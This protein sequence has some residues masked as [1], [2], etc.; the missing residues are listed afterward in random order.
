[1]SLHHV[2]YVAV[3]AGFTIEAVRADYGY[4]A[5]LYTFDAGGQIENGNIYVQLKATDR[6]K[7][8][9]DGF[10][11]FRLDKKDIDL[12]EGEP[13]PVYV[14]LFDATAE[15]AYWLHVQKFLQSSNVTA[16]SLTAKTVPARFDPI[17]VVSVAALDTWRQNK[18]AAL[19]AIGRISHA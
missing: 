8:A 10:I 12:W 15:K 1:M 2:A 13:F 3:K 16:A 17:Q 18:I 14:V 7:I 4:D 6:V 19:R 9:K 11:R 5:S